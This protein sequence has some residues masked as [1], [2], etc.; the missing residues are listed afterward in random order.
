[1]RTIVVIRIVTMMMMMLIET[2]L[3]CTFEEPASPDGDPVTGE[4]EPTQDNE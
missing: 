2:L 3:C 4:D 1:M